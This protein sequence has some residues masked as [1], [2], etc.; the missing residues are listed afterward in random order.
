M[1]VSRKLQVCLASTYYVCVIG[2]VNQNN[3][4]FRIR[5]ILQCFVEI[6]PLL[7]YIIHPRKPEPRTAPLKWHGEVP[8]HPYTITFQCG[9]DDVGVS[10]E[11]VVAEHR[12]R[13]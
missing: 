9:G 8:K 10:Y 12:E 11:V 4:R 1:R 5:N 7:Q 3:Y 13:A 2:F 6:I